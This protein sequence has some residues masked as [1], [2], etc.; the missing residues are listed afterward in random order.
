MI[1]VR[2]ERLV[3]RNNRIGKYSGILSIL[4]LAAGMYFSFR[5]QDQISYSVIALVIGFTLSQVGIFYANRFGRSP[6]PDEELD[7]ALKGLDDQYALY[8]YQSP[9]SHLLVGPAGIWILFPF[10]QKGK[11]VYDSK[12]GRWKKIGGNFYMNFFAQD[13]LGSPESEIA[14]SLK[15]L[16][17]SLE[18]IPE[19]SMPKIQTALVFS[20]EKAVV[21]A[22]NAP[23][24]T[25]HARQLKKLI[26][27]ES[28]GESALSTQ[29]LKTVQDYYGLKSIV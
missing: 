5:Y 21:E 11:I 29:A 15:R 17:K 18:K 13:S 22:D 16:K 24:P 9:V 7:A 14:A 20:N 19:F 23:V 4:I 25:L 2:N 6:R 8:H 27:K 10:P 3:K 12:R 26:R 1:I 28:K